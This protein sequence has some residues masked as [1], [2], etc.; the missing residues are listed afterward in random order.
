M[1]DVR[2][3]ENEEMWY[4]NNGVPLKREDIDRMYQHYMS[5]N[6]GVMQPSGNLLWNRIRTA[7][8][9]VLLV[10][11]VVLAIL[12]GRAMNFESESHVTYIRRMQ[13]ECNDA[14]SM[15]TALSRTAGASS[16][17]TLGK[18]RSHI[19]A[20]DVI[21]QVNA[22]LGNGYL[23]DGDIFT[24]LY[25]IV[26]DYSNRLITGMVTGDQQTGLTNALTSLQAV[27]AALE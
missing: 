17:S 25:T 14:L 6:G 13:T 27:I 8:I 3:Y 12:G 10:A 22:G 19:Y 24:N 18:I 2:L 16:S 26:D 23:V 15:T 4:D 20:M 9:L 5:R 11:V 7:I 1:C 21:N